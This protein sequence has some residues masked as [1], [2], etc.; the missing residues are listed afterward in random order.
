MLV[1]TCRGQF[2]DAQKYRVDRSYHQMDIRHVEIF[3][4]DIMFEIVYFMG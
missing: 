1:I 3:A 4:S 2:Y